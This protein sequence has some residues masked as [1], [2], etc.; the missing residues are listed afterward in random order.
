M[1][2]WAKTLLKSFKLMIWSVGITSSLCDLCA[3]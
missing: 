1:T 3:D 2:I